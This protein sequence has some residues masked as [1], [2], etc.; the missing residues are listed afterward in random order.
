MIKGLRTNLCLILWWNR[1]IKERKGL[2]IECIIIR[3][4]TIKNHSNWL[5][6]IGA[7]ECNLNIQH[8]SFHFRLEVLDAST[9]GAHNS[10]IENYKYMCLCPSFL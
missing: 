6:P 2:I 5:K 9:F 7:K 3:I 8:N 4:I 1:G 10:S